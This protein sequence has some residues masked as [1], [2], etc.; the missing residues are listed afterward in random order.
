[1]HGIQEH[2]KRVKSIKKE[3]GQTRRTFT[4]PEQL[5]TIEPVVT[6]WG[7]QIN[8]IAQLNGRIRQ[9]GVPSFIAELLNILSEALPFDKPQ[10]EN[11]GEQIS[12]VSA[13]HGLDPKRKSDLYI[14][15]LLPL[16]AQEG[17]IERQR[18]ASMIEQRFKDLPQKTGYQ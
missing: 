10:L 15:R 16:M 7:D 12:I 3:I 9:D 18:Q 14:L 1:M 2:A 17:E 13:A 8:Q 6:A 5:L 11:I 4:D